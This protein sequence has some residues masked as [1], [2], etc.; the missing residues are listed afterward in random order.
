MLDRR[1]VK[2]I[3]LPIG[4]HAPDEGNQHTGRDL[5]CRIGQR[6]QTG[7]K[8]SFVKKRV[9]ITGGSAGLPTG[10]SHC[11]A[12]ALGLY[13]IREEEQTENQFNRKDKK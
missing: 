13:N 12:R 1:V 9:G 3:G 7:R 10:R 4:E 5:P 11:V 8:W 6:V 2:A